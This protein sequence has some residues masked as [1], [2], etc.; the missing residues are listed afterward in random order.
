MKKGL[1]FHSPFLVFPA[2]AGPERQLLPVSTDKTFRSITP[3]RAFDLSP[4]LRGTP[5]AFAEG[6]HQGQANVV[7]LTSSIF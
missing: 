3:K 7:K 6:G 2:F 5:S 1:R 4:P